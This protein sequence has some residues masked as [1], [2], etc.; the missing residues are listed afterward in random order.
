MNAVKKPTDRMDI[1][2]L[3]R[4]PKKYANPADFPA[5]SVTT[6]G[7]PQEKS[8][9]KHLAYWLLDRLAN[10]RSCPWSVPSR[11]W[12]A[13][14]ELESLSRLLTEKEVIRIEHVRPNPYMAGSWVVSRGPNFDRLRDVLLE[15]GHR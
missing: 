15:G 7:I 6:N 13:P 3:S 12:D 2:D 11:P 9:R 4:Q 5:G 10:R 1:V 8:L 14:G